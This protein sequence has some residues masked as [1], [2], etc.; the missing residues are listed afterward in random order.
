MNN[1][2]IKK[3]LVPV[4]L[5]EGSLNALDSAVAITKQHKAQLHIVYID[6]PDYSFQHDLKVSLI[7][8]TANPSDILFALSG[9]ISHTHDI[10]PVVYE[11]EGNVSEQI[12]KMSFVQKFDLIVMGKHGASGNRECYI[13]SNTYN[14]IKYANCPVLSVPSRKKITSFGKILFPIR[15]VSRGLSGYEFVS[16]FCNHGTTMD[17]LGLAYRKTDISTGV[18]NAIVDEIRERLIRDQIEPHVIWGESGAVAEDVFNYS[19]HHQTELIVVTNALDLTT[20]PGYIGP[21][22]QKILNIVKVPV[23]SLKNV[24]VHSFA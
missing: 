23:L 14:I 11:K 5:S 7:H 6:E 16:E 17:I 3:I 18:L 9:A 15:P 2:S 8:S 20:K 19:L 10:Q 12:L 22:T 21:H 24:N 1:Y 4:D 13:G